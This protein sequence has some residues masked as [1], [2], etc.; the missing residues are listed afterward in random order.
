MK[1]LFLSLIL[2]SLLLLSA[3]APSPTPLSI[4]ELNQAISPSNTPGAISKDVLLKITPEM[5]YGEIITLLGPSADIGSG[6]HVVM[7][8]VDEQYRFF[9]SFSDF[10]TIAN[11]KGSEQVDSLQPIAHIRGT[12]KNL[13]QGKDGIT[14]LVEGSLDPDTQYD[15]ASVT[16]TKNTIV[17]IQGVNTLVALDFTE[18][19]EGQLVEI[20]FTGAVAESY[21]VQAQA[22]SITIIPE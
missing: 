5:T 19:K 14:F 6:L 16:A 11:L 1:N 12:V 22:G 7:Y 4:E 10:T 20:T 17:T 13:I 2:I 8:T 21:P 15:K 3:C 9:L 18:V